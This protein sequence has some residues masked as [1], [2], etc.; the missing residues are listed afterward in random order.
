M[1]RKNGIHKKSIFASLIILVVIVSAIWVM[2]Y[3]GK[4]SLLKSSSDRVLT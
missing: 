4:N 3:K 1:N 2:Q